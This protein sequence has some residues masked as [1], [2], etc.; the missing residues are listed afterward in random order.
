MYV[1]YITLLS[2]K[3]TFMNSFNKLLNIKMCRLFIYEYLGLLKHRKLYTIPSYQEVTE[4]II[5]LFTIMPVLTACL[6]LFD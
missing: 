6:Y 4:L 1:N 2:Q 3:L 5:F